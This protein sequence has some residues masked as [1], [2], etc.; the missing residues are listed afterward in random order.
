M[1]VVVKCSR[2]QMKSPSVSEADL[3]YPYCVGYNTNNILSRSTH[4]ARMWSP[5][6]LHI[7]VIRVNRQV[8][9][10]FSNVLY[11]T[12]DEGQLNSKY[13]VNLKLCYCQIWLYTAYVYVNRYLQ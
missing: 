3:N 4:C 7:R 13:V 9:R 5:Y 8:K 12:L 11:E 10:H 1:G 6:G 2:M